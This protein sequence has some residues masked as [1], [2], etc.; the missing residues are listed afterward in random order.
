MTF[1]QLSYILSVS[2][3]VNITFDDE[4]TQFKGYIYQMDAQ[5]I[6][7]TR[8]DAQYKVTSMTLDKDNVLSIKLTKS[9]IFEDFKQVQIKDIINYFAKYQTNN[10]LSYFAGYIKVR[11]I[12]KDYTEINTTL[13][14]L[15]KDK[16]L[17]NKCLILLYWYS[18]KLRIYVS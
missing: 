12:S 8:I 11:I 7:E 5:L 14:K 17:Q 18:N 1:N 15:C 4:H 2:Q 3:K 6:E 10:I 9:N 16:W 13:N